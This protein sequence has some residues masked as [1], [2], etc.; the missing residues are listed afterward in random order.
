MSSVMSRTAN[1]LPPAVRSAKSTSAPVGWICPAAIASRTRSDGR[2]KDDQSYLCRVLRGRYRAA[3]TRLRG[4]PCRTRTRKCRFF[5][6]SGELLGFTEHFRTR[7]FSRT[8]RRDRCKSRR[9]KATFASS[10]PICPATQS[11]LCEPRTV[12]VGHSCARKESPACAF[13]GL[14][15]VSSVR[16]N[17]SAWDHCGVTMTEDR[18]Y[19]WYFC[20]AD[21]RFPRLAR[22]RGAP[23]P[24]ARGR[25]GRRASRRGR[26]ACSRARGCA[27]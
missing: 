8:P 10:S 16:G 27:R 18:A 23:W 6:I 11:G 12:S 2:R 15:F 20:F 5:V 25:A 24:R 13:A 14:F 7:D 19:R 17:E 22:D 1:A 4:W 9:V 3:E 21:D 26:A